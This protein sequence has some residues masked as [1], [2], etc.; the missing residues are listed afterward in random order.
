MK[1]KFQTAIC[2]ALLYAFFQ[3]TC[4]VGQPRSKQDDLNKFF[5]ALYK[6]GQFNGNVL[7]AENDK[8]IY[9]RSFGYADLSTK[10]LNTLHTSFPAA[11]ITKTFTSTAILQLVEK[12]KLQLTDPFIM[13]FPAFPYPSVTIIQLLSHTS[14]IPSSA[15]YKLLDSL[16]KIKDTFFVNADVIPAFVEMKK[17]LTG[18]PKPEGDRS[19]FAY[20]NINYYLLALLIEKLTGMPYSSYIK[21]FIFVPA[22]MES[23]SFSEFYFGID[24]N[25]STEHRYRYVYSDLPERIDTVSDN[26][27]I[28]RTYNFKG[29]GDLV[30]TT[31]DL[32]K[33]S[34]A[35]QK[36]V[37]LKENTLM[38]SYAPVVYGN[39]ATSGY[40]LGWSILHDSTKGKIVF[41]HG[42]GM[43]IEAMFIRNIT[44]D[45]TVIV[46]DNMKHH[47]FNT[48]MNALKILNGEKIPMPKKSIAKLYGKAMMKEGVSKANTLLETIKKDSLHYY[49]NEDEMNL[50]GYQFLWNNMNDKAYEVLKLNLELFPASWNSYDSYGEILLKIGRKEEAIKMYKRS[51]ELNPNNDGGKKVLEQIAKGN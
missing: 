51:I 45:Q 37:L 46:F 20:S 24:K 49:L 3:P 41:H 32:L 9:E 44:K 31:Q 38:Q 23:S 6:N 21:K 33:Y 47:A 2:I 22:G 27:Y 39:P 40:G 5:S 15:F 7:I 17:P 18:E 25:L 34:R 29:H 30:S 14:R 8:I 26:A 48:S 11:S 13:Y 4:L 42:G 12:G 50:L 28:F 36:N 35:L 10:K 19:V 43:G 1:Y 16:R